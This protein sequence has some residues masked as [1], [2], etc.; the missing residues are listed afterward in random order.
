MKRKKL[1]SLIFLRDNHICF[2]QSF[3]QREVVID[4]CNAIFVRDI[5]YD[6]R[7]SPLRQ[8]ELAQQV[9]YID[10]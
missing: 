3:E 2:K 1:S 6:I 5:V 7:L 10:I 9:G 8:F 4:F